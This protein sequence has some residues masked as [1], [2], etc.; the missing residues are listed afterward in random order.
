MVYSTCLARPLV[1][2]FDLFFASFFAGILL[3]NFFVF[4]LRFKFKFRDS[5]AASLPL[6]RTCCVLDCLVVLLLLVF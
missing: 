1:I 4:A 6:A 2:V 3:L 5:S